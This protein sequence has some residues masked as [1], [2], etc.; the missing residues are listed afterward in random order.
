M[1]KSLAIR[2]PKRMIELR[3]VLGWT[4]I[5]LLRGSSCKC[6]VSVQNIAINMHI[7]FWC[8]RLP[9]RDVFELEFSGWSEPKLWMFQAEPFKLGHFNFWAETELTK[10]AIFWHWLK[11]QVYSIVKELSLGVLLAEELENLQTKSNS[12]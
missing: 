9:I 6:W 5:P 2:L 4:F 1:G 12:I 3:S 10:E 11:I 7:L 8:H